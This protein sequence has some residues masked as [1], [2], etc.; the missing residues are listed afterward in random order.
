M[1]MKKIVVSGGKRVIVTNDGLR[2]IIG[3][4][5]PPGPP[6]PQGEIGQPGGDVS[7]THD[8]IIAKKTWFVHHSLDKYPSV[9]V[10]DSAG[11]LVYGTVEY[12]SR[13]YIILT[14]TAEFSGQAYLN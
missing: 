9:S 1:R 10:V 5:G 14:F 13:D 8:Q 2:V 3:T 11:N 4:Q 7:Y 6:G 12:V